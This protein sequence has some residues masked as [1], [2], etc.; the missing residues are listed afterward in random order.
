M[1]LFPSFIVDKRRFY[2]RNSTHLFL[3]LPGNNSNSISSGIKGKRNKGVS[4]N[5]L[6]LVLVGLC[7]GVTLGVAFVPLFEIECNVSLN[8]S[9]DE[10]H[11][12][13]GNHKDAPLAFNSGHETSGGRS[14]KVDSE[15]KANY[16]AASRQRNA[17]MRRPRFFSTE[18]GLRKKLIAGIILT[19]ISR[20]ENVLALNRTLG[21]HVNQLLFF[22]VGQNWAKKL[23]SAGLS[24]VVTLTESK[25]SFRNRSSSSFL[26]LDK[27][28]Y[29]RAALKVMRYFGNKF[30]DGFDYFFVGIDVFYI[31]G[32]NLMKSVKN[33]SISQNVIWGSSAARI[34]Q[35]IC[36]L[37]EHLLL[38]SFQ[39]FRT[40]FA[41]NFG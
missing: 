27:P 16:L 23:K 28:Q 12:F 22:A 11:V 32:K 24:G 40:D 15:I 2:S 9:T 19:D 20:I 31:N 30:A 14:S 6:Q 5:N 37:G 4:S 25:D 1:N 17:F 39:L 29:N 8:S 35:D 26:R 21:P 18:L 10:N 13:N 34:E 33:I 41:C 3:L 36:R 7:L 38:C